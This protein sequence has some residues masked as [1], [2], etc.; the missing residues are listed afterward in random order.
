LWCVRTLEIDVNKMVD[1]DV[2]M[3]I[4]MDRSSAT[5]VFASKKLRTGTINKPPPKPNKPAMNPT[6]AP[7]RPNTI[8]T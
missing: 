7:V 5:P 6:I 2:T 4:L 8:K 3:A 1:M